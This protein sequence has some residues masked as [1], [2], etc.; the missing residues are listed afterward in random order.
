MATKRV[1][2]PIA[3]NQLIIENNE[4]TGLGV[5]KII[6]GVENPES[7]ETLVDPVTGYKYARNTVE[8]HEIYCL[9]T[10]KHRP[11][12]ILDLETGSR[13]WFPG[14]IINGDITGTDIPLKSAPSHES[15]TLQILSTATVQILEIDAIDEE[16]FVE[17]WH[18]VL[19]DVEGYVEKKFITNLRYAD[20]TRI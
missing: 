14:C 3:D 17:G 8:T 9:K 16:P 20:P 5:A 15:E 13:G 12:F 2:H 1:H 4:Y 6:V 19:F 11:W 7:R 10:Q 18:K